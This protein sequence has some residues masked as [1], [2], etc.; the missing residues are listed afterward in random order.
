MNSESRITP[1]SSA[2]GGEPTMTSVNEAQACLQQMRAE[3]RGEPT[4]GC[5]AQLYALQR[6]REHASFGHNE[7]LNIPSTNLRTRRTAAAMNHSSMRS[8]S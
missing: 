2:A 8:R 6:K 5:S 4:V 3:A 1:L 7:P